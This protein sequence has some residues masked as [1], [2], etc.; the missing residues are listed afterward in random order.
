MK[1]F[2]ISLRK[3]TVYTRHIKMI[4][5][6]YPRRQPTTTFLWPE[7]TKEHVG[8]LAEQDSER[9][10][11]LCR[12]KNRKKF[13]VAVKSSRTTHVLVQM[14]AYLWQI[15]ILSWQGGPHIS[16]VLNQLP[17]IIP[18]TNC[19]RWNAMY[20]LMNSELLLKQRQQFGI[21]H[22]T[23]L[24][25]QTKYLQRSIKQEV[26]Q[27]QRHLQSCFTA[28]EGGRLSHTNSRMQP[29]FTHTKE[30]VMLKSVTTI[31]PSL[32]FIVYRWED[33]AKH[34]TESPAWTLWSGWNSTRNSVS[35]LQDRGTI[36]MISP[37]RQFQEQY[38]KHLTQSVVMG[39]W[40]LWQSLAIQPGL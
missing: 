7:Q 15:K 33:S 16:Y 24:L 4:L 5:A 34:P 25:V 35:I 32:Y 27:W 36:D 17:T 28:Y 26:N 2:K 10:P 19:H 11:V 31:E 14:E 1:K 6:Q 40:K 39:F 23:R 3:N 21:C 8:F 29:L 18:P 9:N 22:R 30:K 12:Q 13:H 37:A 20:C 38:Q